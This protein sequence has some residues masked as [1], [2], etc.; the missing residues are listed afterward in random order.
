MDPRIVIDPG[1]HFAKPCV[2]GTRIPVE[3]I[4]ELIEAG[5]SF[6]QIRKD[7]YPDLTEEDLKACVRFARNVLAAEEIHLSPSPS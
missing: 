1:V 7:Y 6:D 5:L 2:A 4:I 3:A